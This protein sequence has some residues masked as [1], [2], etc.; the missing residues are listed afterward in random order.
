MIKI[1]GVKISGI[2]ACVP[3]SVVNNEGLTENQK[4]INSIG[5]KQRHISSE[6]QH[7]MDLCVFAAEN[8]IKEIS[9]GFYVTDMI[10]SSVSMVTGDYSRG[11]KWIL[12]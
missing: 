4:L 7:T 9:D 5:V 6:N 3:K 8:L 11:C 2:S 10:G 1:D 12:D